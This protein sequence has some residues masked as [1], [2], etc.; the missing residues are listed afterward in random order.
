MIKLLI[1][2]TL[3]CLTISIVEGNPLLY[4]LMSG[5]MNQNRNTYGGQPNYQ[6]SPYQ[7]PR[8]SSPYPFGAP[9]RS[10]PYSYSVP[11]I[12]SPYAQPINVAPTTYNRP[13]VPLGSNYQ[14]GPT[15]AFPTFNNNNRQPVYIDNGPKPA[16]NGPIPVMNGPIAGSPKQPAVQS[17]I[18]QGEGCLQ[19]VE[20]RVYCG[21]NGTD[22]T[23]CETMGCCWDPS[24]I[25]TDRL[26]CFF[27]TEMSNFVAPEVPVEKPSHPKATFVPPQ[28]FAPPQPKN[29]II[30]SNS[31]LDETAC[32]A[33]KCA[34]VARSD[35]RICIPNIE[36]F[37]Q[38]RSIC[39]SVGCC[40]VDN[41]CHH[42]NHEVSCSAPAPTQPSAPAVP[43]KPSGLLN[44]LQQMES[45]LSTTPMSLLNKLK[46]M[47]SNMQNSQGPST[48][49]KLQSLESQMQNKQSQPPTQKPYR[50][51]IQSH[52]YQPV[53][54]KAARPVV[55]A[56]QQPYQPIYQPQPPPT[57]QYVRQC[58]LFGCRM[59]PVPGNPQQNAYQ[60]PV[61]VPRNN[62][63]TCFP[64]KCGD[65]AFTPE[66]IDNDFDPRKI[67]GG[68]RA[69]PFSH[70]WTVMIQKSEGNRTFICGATLICQQWLMT[71]AHCLDQQSEYKNTPDLDPNMYKIFIGRW[72]GW[73]APHGKQVQIFKGNDI[74]RMFQ[75]EKF[76][77]GKHRG[78]ITHDIALIKLRKLVKMDDFAQPA[79]LPTE[80][81]KAKSVMFATGWGINRNKGPKPT[82]LK[83]VGVE[84]KDKIS[85]TNRVPGFK[86]PP[87]VICGGGEPFH[88]TCTGDSGGPLV[89]SK[90]KSVY[91]GTQMK[92]LWYVYGLTSIG[93]PSCN[94]KSYDRQPA[95]Y[96]DV[97]YFLDW[98]KARTNNCCA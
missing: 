28:N 55:P 80:P 23:L 82:T 43:N 92:T 9:S 85:C 65:P 94:T 89:G 18:P 93:S 86:N 91:L 78:V 30:S 77:P 95:L 22:Q 26:T 58:N 4:M 57:P 74:E 41:M 60:P 27:H 45:G 44:K 62:D 97:F 10:S 36:T 72:A 96:T 19:F 70:P 15:P 53:N 69:F 11:S 75:H 90:S 34:A 54:P 7:Q 33:K 31:R 48:L 79:C 39:D 14:G 37:Q 63:G 3:L 68:S 73:Q 81:P 12:S 52:S 71:A 49:Q 40:Y 35:R 20:N 2:S 67:V 24:A 83:Q 1:V 16:S 47:E 46:Q 50:P 84:I 42:A 29:A 6:S 76:I 59:V 98:I 56:N 88:D 8:P 5:R 87:G 66:K 64:Q 21:S 25:G 61:Q 51:T 32:K 38:P 13:I 17:L